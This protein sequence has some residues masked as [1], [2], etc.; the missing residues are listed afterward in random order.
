[1]AF[2]REKQD[3]TEDFLVLTPGIGLDV[4]GDGLGQQYRTSEMAALECGCDI[5][6]VRRG[7]YGNP[8]NMD[9]GEVQRQAERYREAGWNAYLKRLNSKDV[10]RNQ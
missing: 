1:L 4:A 10:C 2:G 3:D 9:I 8:G 6:I 7:I 5:I